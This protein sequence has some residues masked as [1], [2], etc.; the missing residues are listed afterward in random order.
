MRNI[1]VPTMVGDEHARAIYCASRLV[2]GYE[3]IR[4][5]GADYPT[6]QVV[7][8]YFRNEKIT[9]WN[10]AGPE[11]QLSNH[12]FDV[13]W[14]RRPVEPVLPKTLHPDDQHVANIENSRF[15]RSLWH[16]LGTEATWINPYHAHLCASYKIVQLREAKTAGFTSPET[17]ISNDPEQ[18]VA[19]IR[20]HAPAKTIYKSFFPARWKM[21][22][23]GSAVLETSVVSE[24]MLPSPDTLRL[25]PGIF[26]PRIEKAYE[27]RATFFGAHVVAL[28]FSSPKDHEPLTDWRSMYMKDLKA[29]PVELP[30]HIY[31]SCRQL[32]A[33]LGIVFGCF[34]FIVTPDH[35]FVFLEV[36]EMGQF[37]WK[38]YLVPETRMLDIFLAFLLNPSADFEWCPS[39][40]GLSFRSLMDSDEY[41]HIEE[42]EKALHVESSPWG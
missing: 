39:R 8:F 4:W 28:K 13:V 33:S 5:F 34:D 14:L 21:P 6:R 12:K 7:S 32:M 2:E 15:Y 41:R 11:L 20:K 26:Q 10:I 17:L 9:E 24:S 40:K 36:N 38:E 35:E 22:Q 29:E 23:N 30:Q 27:I 16:M 19:F 18:I 3:V 1:L 31:R 25:T 42:E 37:L